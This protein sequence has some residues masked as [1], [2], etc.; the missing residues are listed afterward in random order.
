MSVASP[1]NPVRALAVRRWLGRDGAVLRRKLAGDTEGDLA[2]FVTI[3]I[4]GGDDDGDRRPAEDIAEGTAPAAAIGAEK[5]RQDQQCEAETGGEYGQFLRIEAP[6]KLAIDAQATHQIDVGAAKVGHPRKRQQHER[7]PE[8]HRRTTPGSVN[9][10]SR[11]LP[12][13]RAGNSAMI[14]SRAS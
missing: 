3:V 8:T 5:G 2:E 1:A 12:A 13:C 6:E 4:A 7:Q 14:R 9:V 11:G 10:V